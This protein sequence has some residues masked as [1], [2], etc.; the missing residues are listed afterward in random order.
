MEYSPEP[1]MA[2]LDK[3]RT[4]IR[5]ADQ[6]TAE[7]KKKNS[8]YVTTGIVASALST[9]IAGTA[10]ALG[11]VIGQALTGQLTPG[12]AWKLTCGAIAVCTGIATVFSGLQK[13]LSIAERLVKASACSGKLHALEFAITVNNRETSEVAREYEMAIA[14]Y[15][16]IIL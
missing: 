14:S 8:R 10:A 11:P 5:K 3:I 6:E 7:L 9:V 2:L 15:P 16:E 4:G 12:P 1:R 13:Q